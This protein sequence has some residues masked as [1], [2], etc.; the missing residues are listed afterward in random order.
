MLQYLSDWDFSLFFYSH[1]NLFFKKNCAKQFFFWPN[2]QKIYTYVFQKHTNFYT[3]IPSIFVKLHNWDDINPPATLAIPN[4]P[5]LKRSI[6][7]EIIANV[8][9]QTKKHT[10][11][12]HIVSEETILFWLL[13]YVLWPLIT[14]HKCA[15]TIQGRKL[16]EEIR[17]VLFTLPQDEILCSK[18]N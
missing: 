4:Y 12:P 9:S 16:Y 15:E 2:V 8:S 18:V 1:L 7:Y 17:Y 11:F 5:A 13:P 10:V 14:V 6:R 3:F